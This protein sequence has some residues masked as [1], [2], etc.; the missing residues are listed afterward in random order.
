M[1][2]QKSE[3]VYARTSTPAVVHASPQTKIVMGKAEDVHAG[4]VV[5]VT[6]SAENDHSISAEQIV[7][8]TGYVKVQ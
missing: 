6:G 2:Q 8:L 5:H 3:T 4:A 7:I 1:L